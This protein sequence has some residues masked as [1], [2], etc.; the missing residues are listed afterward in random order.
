MEIATAAI[1]GTGFGMQALSERTEAKV[2]AGAY[3]YQAALAA[4]EAEAIRRAGA[5][6]AREKREEG[7]RFKGRQLAQLAATGKI[8][9]V[10]TP[11]SLLAET[12]Y[13]IA[14]DIKILESQYGL[15]SGRAVAESRLE[16]LFAKGATRAGRYKVGSTL[17]TG[18][19][20]T[21]TA[22]G[23]LKTPSERKLGLIS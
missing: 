10:G 17:L 8:P 18:A 9:T 2:A 4:K 23:W 20:R 16:R 3:K 14:K 5:L 21:G 19:Y 12:E 7:R 1:I 22:A 15:A 11:L 13:E 6:E